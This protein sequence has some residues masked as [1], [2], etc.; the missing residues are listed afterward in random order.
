MAGMADA[1]LMIEAG[2]RSGT[3][4]TARLASEYNRDLLCVPHRIND[5]NGYGAQLFLRLGATLVASPEHILE[6][7]GLDTHNP[8][9][10][11]PGLTD[12]EHAIYTLLRTPMNK[13]ELLRTSTFPKADLLRVLVMLDLKGC[14]R[15]ELG[16]WR[17]VR[18][19]A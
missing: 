18:N 16:A 2:E 4:I 1:I 9:E 3:L 13:E 11:L 15:E 7:L 5:P 8:D 6:A 17:R 10:R 14:A 19:N 12:E